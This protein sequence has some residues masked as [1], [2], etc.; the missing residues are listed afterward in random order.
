VRFW[1]VVKVLFESVEKTLKR[2]RFWGVGGV[3][4]RSAEKALK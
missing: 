1:I 4:F 2:V 3:F